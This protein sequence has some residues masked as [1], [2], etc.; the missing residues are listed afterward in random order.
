MK[1]LKHAIRKI[2]KRIVLKTSDEIHIKKIDELA[3]TPTM[4][5]SLNCVMCHQKEIKH[6]PNM[7][8][9]DFKKLLFNLKKE[10][11]KKIS[12][13]GGEIFVHPEMWKFIKLMEKMKFQYDLSSNLFFVPNMSRLRQ[14]SG[15][16]MVTTSIDGD[17]AVHDKI[18]NV[19]GAYKKT[20]Q[21]I[22]IL[23]SWGIK[24]DVACVAQKAN[25]H[26]LRNIVSDIC[27][28][29]VKSITL[30]FENTLTNPQKLANK[31]LIK[32][33]TGED[34]NILV[35][36]IEN[37]LGT[38]SEDDFKYIVKLTPSLIKLAKH[39][40]ANLHLATQF[41]YPELLNQKC[42]LKNYTCGI[43]KGY[44]MIAYNK[45]E[46]PFCG[47]ITLE[48]DF[49]L[50]SNKPLSVA[51]SKEYIKLRRAFKKYGALPMCRLCCA[52]KKK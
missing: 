30:L 22:K 49:D 27:K 2:K 18:R 19:P 50:L 11:V 34:S 7:E 33:I 45:G 17:E 31:G 24:I 16:E 29:K 46:L 36:S 52:L 28:L 40:G 8:Y 1:L 12:L 3:I 13:V 41:I 4:K 23:K 25:L 48:K 32:K 35:S 15:L 9:E 26:M 5:C 43:F 47:F 6:W 42:S 20:V 37:P 10:G 44:N 38:M 21:N 39:H 14:L 51:N